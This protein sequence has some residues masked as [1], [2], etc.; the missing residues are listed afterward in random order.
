[1]LGIVRR[2]LN[3]S[4]LKNLANKQYWPSNINV[5]RIGHFRAHFAQKPFSKFFVR[6]C[7]TGY[8]DAGN[9]LINE[10]MLPT[11][12]NIKPK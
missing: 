6:H 9:P 3:F 2:T 12:C 7:S 5:P 10:L 4:L 11:H 1:M 8:L